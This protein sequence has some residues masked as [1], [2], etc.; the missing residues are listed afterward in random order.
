MRPGGWLQPLCPQLSLQAFWPTGPL[1]PTRPCSGRAEAEL[2]VVGTGF[3]F[4]LGGRCPGGYEWGL[5]DESCLCSHSGTPELC[6]LW[7]LCQ[8]SPLPLLILEVRW[9]E[10]LKWGNAAGGSL[11]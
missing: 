6:S 2:W 4:F 8:G 11:S 5:G 9:V 10:V 7:C 1:L 3:H